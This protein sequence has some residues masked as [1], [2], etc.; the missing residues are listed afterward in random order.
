MA[1]KIEEVEAEIAVGNRSGA[2][3]PIYEA[4]RALKI[5]SVKKL[6]V[7]PFTRKEADSLQTSVTGR[8]KSKDWVA[9][10]LVRDANGNVTTDKEAVYVFIYKT[11]K[12]AK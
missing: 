9:H 10:A 4:V 11:P 7:G 12:D 2:Y 8:C 6:R 5:D 1:F 3:T